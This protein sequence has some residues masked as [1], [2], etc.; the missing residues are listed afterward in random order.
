L[1]HTIHLKTCKYLLPV[2][3][4]VGFNRPPKI[5]CFLKSK[6]STD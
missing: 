4:Y 1:E 5:I 6:F 2:F 3:L